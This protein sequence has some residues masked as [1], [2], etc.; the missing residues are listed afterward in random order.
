MSGKPIFTGDFFFD[1]RGPSLVRI[2]WAHD[3]KVLRA[4]DF[5]GTR[6]K[7]HLFFEGMQVYMVTP[8]DV[9]EL[10]SHDLMVVD[11]KIYSAVTLGKSEWLSTFAP[12]YLDK[13][14]HYKFLFYDEMIDVICEDVEVRAGYYQSGI[15]QP[16][17]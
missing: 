8:E 6:G 12:W 11:G 3:G 5:D 13:C 16:K 10:D 9:I 7:A 15:I 14:E 2:H 17:N 4:I 1:G